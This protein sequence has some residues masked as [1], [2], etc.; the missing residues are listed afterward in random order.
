MSKE[1]FEKCVRC[2]GK[3]VY[4]ISETVIYGYP[5]RQ[6]VV[7]NVPRLEC[8]KCGFMMQAEPDQNEKT[9]VFIDFLKSISLRNYAEIIHT[10]HLLKYACRLYFLAEND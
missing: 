8:Q 10:I 2:H 5:E 4:K 1:V 7:K 6:L 3:T 9:D